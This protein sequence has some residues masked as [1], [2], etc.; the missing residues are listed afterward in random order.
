[1]EASRPRVVIEVPAVTDTL[2]GPSR[3]IE[4]RFRAAA[5]NTVTHILELQRPAA[6]RLARWFWMPVD[7]SAEEAVEALQKGVEAYFQRMI[8]M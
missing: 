3:K 1:M 8:V 5:V 2:I 6:C 7:I 4:D